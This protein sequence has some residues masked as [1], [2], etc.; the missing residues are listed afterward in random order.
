MSMSSNCVELDGTIPLP[1]RT[2]VYLDM[3]SRPARG[4]I[5]GGPHRRTW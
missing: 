2:L 1:V 4:E 3:A 5:M